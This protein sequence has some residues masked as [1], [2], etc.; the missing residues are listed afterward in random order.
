MPVL[1]CQY[2]HIFCEK[3]E[4]ILFSGI[5]IRFLP[6][7]RGQKYDALNGFSVKIFIVYYIVKC[8]LPFTVKG[9]GY[10]ETLSVGQLL[11]H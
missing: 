4:N 10:Y 1:Q 3:F 6:R 11:R 7:T 5:V 9:F 2:R 8:N